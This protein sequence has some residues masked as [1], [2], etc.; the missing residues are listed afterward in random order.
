MQKEKLLYIHHS[1]NFGGAPRSLSYLLKN[2]DHNIY[3]IKLINIRKKGPINKFFKELCNKFNIEFEIV[4]GVMPFHGSTVAL[5]SIKH[6]L[7]NMVFVFPS[8]LKAFRVLKREEPNIIHLNSTCLFVFA[9]ASKLVNKDIKVIAHVREP[10]RNSIS[11]RITSFFVKKYCDGLVAISNYDLSTLSI[12][13]TKSQI[14]SVVIHNF[15]D[16]LDIPLGLEKDF[17]LHER[18]DI[19][20]KAIVFLYLARFAKGNGWEELISVAENVC[21]SNSQFH[22]VLVGAHKE[23]ELN[24]IKN[25]NIHLLL[26][27]K[28]IKSLLLNSDVFICP[29]TEPH[30]SRGIIEASYSSLPVISSNISSVNELVIHNKTGFLYDD[31]AELISYI[32]K[33]GSN[34]NL[35]ENMG[36]NANK[37]AKENFN[38]KIQANKTFSFYRKI[39]EK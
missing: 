35:R 5:K 33:L 12:R 19:P 28:D 25:T 16:E 10:L 13:K 32:S 6:L 22:F 7:I 11:G 17:S 24:Y 37:F 29:F 15:V 23:E 36:I 27:Q 3:K 18:L 2:I 34:K 39:L 9:I 31:Q 21:E 30:F 1:G 26:F 20:R 14:S 4:E 38:L 8:F